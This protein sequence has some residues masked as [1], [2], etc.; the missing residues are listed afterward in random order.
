MHHR[1]VKTEFDSALTI[2]SSRFFLVF[3]HISVEI[4]WSVWLKTPLILNLLIPVAL[5]QLINKILNFTGDIC[6]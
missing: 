1:F 5:Y 2:I 4:D 6:K 3:Q